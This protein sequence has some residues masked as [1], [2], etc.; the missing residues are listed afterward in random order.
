MEISEGSSS[1]SFLVKLFPCGLL[2]ILIFSVLRLEHAGQALHIPSLGPLVAEADLK[3]LILHSP[4]H[5][6]YRC[7][8]PCPGVADYLT[9]NLPV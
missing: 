8:T 5:W 2:V 7:E 4:L 3:F 1:A 9:H 6:D